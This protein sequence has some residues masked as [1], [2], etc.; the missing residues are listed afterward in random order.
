[1]RK[2]LALLF[3]VCQIALAQPVIYAGVGDGVTDNTASWNSAQT[4]ICSS[5][6]RDLVVPAGAYRFLS[7][8]NPRTCT[9]NVR[10]SSKGATHLVK[11]YSGNGGYFFKIVQNSA[12]YYGGGSIRDCTLWAGPN[13]TD[14]IAI[15]VYATLDCC[16]L[17]QTSRN[18]HGFLIDNVAIGGDVGGGVWGY[19]IYLDGSQNTA[20]AIGIR[21]VSIHNTMVA[22]STVADIYL[23]NAVGTSLISTECY[24]SPGWYLG[25]DGASA[26]TLIVSRTCTPTI[27]NAIDTHKWP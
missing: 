21:A 11:D 9:M 1:M 23:Y 10:C 12:D 14:G 16:G 2:L 24:G 20:N 4:A 5:A 6:N 17:T 13:S 19:G 7:P 15:W 25:L 26:A 3:L 8:P 18:A 22:G 27:I